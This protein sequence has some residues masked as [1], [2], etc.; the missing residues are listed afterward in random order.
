MA[1]EFT[2]CAGTVGAGIW[3]SRDSG[4]RWKRAKMELP[5]FS[6]AGDIQVR[7]LAV[8]PHDRHRV[9]AGS[10]VGLYRSDNNGASWQLLDS[11]MAGTQIWSLALDP[12]DPDVILAGTK[13]PGIFRS[14]DGGKSWSEAILNGDATENAWRLWEF[15]WVVP[16]PGNYTLMARATDS[17]GR[18]QPMERDAD[19]NNYRICHCLP[20]EVEVRR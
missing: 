6:R 8:S 12:A 19:A 20:I 13:P 2:I 5:F 18:I 7:A 3:Y 16:A 9:Y 4:E 15:E 10:E 1:T 17:R 11:P 14:R